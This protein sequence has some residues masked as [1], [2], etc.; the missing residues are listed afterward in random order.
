MVFYI[1]SILSC[2]VIIAVLN[3]VFSIPI[4]GFSVLYIILAVIISTV[5]VILID[6]I[7]AFMVRRFLPEKWFSA[8][9]TIYKAG[10]RECLWYERLGIK[11]WKDKILELGALSGF[12]KN[13][14]LKPN[15]NKYVERYILEANYGVIVHLSNMVLGFL[16]IFIYPLKYC[17]CFGVPVAIV[18]FVLS[19]LPMMVLRY[20]LP[21]LHTLRKYN[22]RRDERVVTKQ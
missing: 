6:A 20:N 2:M 7:L 13:H 14:V 12:R 18:N 22:K 16:I 17:L 4:Y 10:K 3:A 11:R 21:K 9:K 15:D 5:S 19:L 8:D 1:V